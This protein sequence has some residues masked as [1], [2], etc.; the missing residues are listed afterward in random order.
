MEVTAARRTD[1]QLYGAGAGSTTSSSSAAV[2]GAEGAEHV[3]VTAGLPQSEAALEA[4]QDCI[5]RVREGPPS[6]TTVCFYA[7]QHT[8]QL[9]NTAEVSADSRL[10]A[11]GFDNSA[12]KLW[13]LRARKLKA[14]PHRTDVSQIRLACDLLEEE[15]SVSRFRQLMD[16]H[17][18]TF[19]R[20]ITD[21]DRFHSFDGFQYVSIC[22]LWNML[23]GFYYEWMNESKSVFKQ[24]CNT[25]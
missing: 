11:A 12:V 6:L 20:E 1:Y 14:G 13:S 25:L 15:V 19:T 2:D 24:K 16:I 3:E 9:L 22:L 10:L 5:K 21:L 4:L 17:I 7:F 23:Q 18:H 8:D